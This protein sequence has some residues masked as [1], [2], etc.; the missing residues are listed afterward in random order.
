[1]GLGTV[2]SI[3]RWLENFWE[4]CILKICSWRKYLAIIFSNSVFK[5]LLW[6]VKDGKKYFGLTEIWKCGFTNHR[7][8]EFGTKL[9]SSVSAY[10]EFCYLESPHKLMV[11]AFS[12]NCNIHDALFSTLA[13]PLSVLS[14][15]CRSPICWLRQKEWA[16][17][18]KL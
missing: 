16:N 8:V 18:I 10:K 17:K 4:F 3:Y 1:M 14:H 5:K 13:L 15:I 9:V 11:W 7:K 12:L 2:P 6:A